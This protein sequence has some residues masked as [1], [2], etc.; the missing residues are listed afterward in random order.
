[1]QISKT[2]LSGWF[3][4]LSKAL[5]ASLLVLL[6]TPIVEASDRYPTEREMQQ[7]RSELSRKI[8]ELRSGE[9]S[10][11]LDDYR[12]EAEK[13]QHQVLVNAWSKVNPSIAPFLGMWSGYEQRLAIYPSS[14]QG[15]VCIIEISEVGFSH[16]ATGMVVNNEEIRT[17]DRRFIIRNGT[18]LGSIGVYGDRAF[19]EGKI[20][21]KT[22]YP[23]FVP[24]PSTL[25]NEEVE[26][27]E[28]I[29]QA[30]QQFEEAHCSASLPIRRSH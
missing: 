1:M 28:Q 4:K 6:L 9:F 27:E 3:K 30:L 2:Q 29:K 14:I 17:S 8:Q 12:T 23:L 11:Y 24:S 26:S 19:L 21:W 10:N 20:P 15:Q 18:Y 22:P 5:T 13:Q 16:L 25:R 7:L